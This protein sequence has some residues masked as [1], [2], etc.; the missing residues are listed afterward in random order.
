MQALVKEI[1]KYSKERK[2]LH[3][4]TSI[5]NMSDVFSI[6]CKRLEVSVE[7][8]DNLIT[9]VKASTPLIEENEPLHA[10]EKIG[11]YSKLTSLINSDRMPVEILALSKRC[12]AALHRLPFDER[13][14]F[15]SDT[16]LLKVRIRLLMD[17]GNLDRL[18][19]ILEG[20]LLDSGVP[21]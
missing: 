11:G 9:A 8:T 1:V 6:C 19:E 12:A 15:P 10:Q 5:L 14:L 13:S 3:R 18:K 17:K 16:E 2:L 20:D 7:A 4:G 21:L